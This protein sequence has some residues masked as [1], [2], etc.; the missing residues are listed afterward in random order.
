MSISWGLK[1]SAHYLLRYLASVIT[2][3]IWLVSVMV[4][5]KYKY[6][7]VCSA[8]K[9]CNISVYGVLCWWFPLYFKINKKISLVKQIF[10]SYM[11]LSIS[12]YNMMTEIQFI[13]QIN[14]V[15]SRAWDRLF[16]SELI[17]WHNVHSDLFLKSEFN[18]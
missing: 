4:D 9:Y 7:N 15:T 14:S 6:L 12:L 16:R 13:I 8:I 18:S 11:H 10:W 5:G 1:A 17:K 3:G 2:D